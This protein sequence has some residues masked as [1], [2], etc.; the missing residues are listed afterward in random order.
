M[1]IWTSNWLNLFLKRFF[2]RKDFFP[3]FSAAFV[4]SR[5]ASMSVLFKTLYSVPR[6]HLSILAPIMHFLNYHNFVVFCC[7]IAKSRLPLC[8]PMNYSSPC[9]CVL[10]YL[11]EFQTLQ[12]VLIILIYKSYFILTPLT[13]LLFLSTVMVILG[14]LYFVWI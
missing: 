2:S 12:L 6:Y 7:S 13:L 9:F 10:H 8:D 5:R 4:I 14:C 1:F 11:P 3:H